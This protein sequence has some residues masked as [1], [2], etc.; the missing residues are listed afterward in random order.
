M[1]QKP[2]FN[3][4]V[5][6]IYV[7]WV[8]NSIWDSTVAWVNLLE[9]AFGAADYDEAGRE[10]TVFFPRIDSTAG[11]VIQVE[12]RDQ[13]SDATDLLVVGT[14]D[15]INIHKQKINSGE[16]T[17]LLF[18]VEKRDSG[19]HQELI[20]WIAPLDKSLDKLKLSRSRFV[21]G[22]KLSDILG[23]HWLRNS[24]FPQPGGKNNPEQIAIARDA[25]HEAI[26]KILGH[27]ESCED[28][29]YE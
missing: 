29:A 17:E 23:W 24:R 28:C 26:D 5:R 12:Q 19:A 22:K 8:P 9:K 3:E 10:I 20:L 18:F 6:K 1:P 15:Y 27:I 2:S 14:S 11:S 7:S 13:L 25:I 16:S 4:P 21:P